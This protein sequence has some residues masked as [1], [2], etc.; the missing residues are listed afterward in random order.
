MSACVQHS[1]QPFL[2]RSVSAEEKLGEF[3]ARWERQ[4]PLLWV[5]VAAA[6]GI[7]IDRWASF[8]LLPWC[9][10]AVFLF[11]LT[12]VL[13]V[14]RRLCISAV[15]LL[16]GVG[17]VSGIWHHDR[18]NIYPV[19]EVSRLAGNEPSPLVVRVMVLDAPRIRPA[20]EEGPLLTVPRGETTR[21]R[22]RALA[23]REGTEWRRVSG[24]LALIVEG[25]VEQLKAWRGDQLEV[26]ALLA[27]VR[28]PL[29]PGEPNFASMYR[30]RRRRAVLLC[31]HV[32]CIRR[33]HSGRWWSF[34]RQL[35]RLRHE[36]EGVLERYVGPRRGPLAAALLLGARHRL[37]PET[38]NTFFLSGSLHFLA[39]SG[40]HVGIL[41]TAF[42]LLLRLQWLPR[43]HVLWAAGIVVVNYALLTGARP[44]V[45]RA[46]ILIVLYCAARGTGRFS[47]AW[48]SL[49]AAGLVTLALC[50]AGLFD[51]GTQLSFLAVASLICLWPIFAPRAA[52]D[53]LRQLIIRS[54]PP[55][56]RLV[57]GGLM[58]AGR[59]LLV[60]AVVWS[61]SVPLVAY[62]FHLIAPVGL[63]LTVLL[64]LPLAAALFAA[65]LTVLTAPLPWLPL[66]F[67]SCCDVC[68]A[69]IEWLTGWAAGCGWGHAW[70]SGPPWWWCVV[71]YGGLFSWRFTPL[72]QLNKRWWIAIC[73][74][75]FMVWIACGS[76]ATRMRRS[77]TEQP[78]R[79]SF[80]AVGHG[81]AVLVELP[82]G[83]TLLYDAGRMGS[84][85]SAVLPVSSVLWA[86]RIHHID[87]LVLSHADADHYNAV[88][89]LLDR[90]SVGIVYV[91][92]VMFD[93][94][95]PGL[96]VLQAA[97]EDARVGWAELEENMMLDTGTGVE[98]RVA[99]PPPRG[100]GGRTAGGGD[101][102]NSVVLE[103]SF[104][105]HRTLLTGDLEGRGLDEL[106]A[107]LPARTDVLLAPH[108]G[109]PRSRPAE[110]VKWAKPTFVVI[111]AGAGFR[112]ER[113]EPV[114]G[115]NGARV[116]WT[117]RDGMVEMVSDGRRLQVSAW[118]A[119]KK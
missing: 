14:S 60:S 53:P 46:V 70:V 16:S 32:E 20:A 95:D 68:L 52:G 94:Q 100:C 109:S 10:L 116:F 41:A 45:V 115:G 27:R 3:R 38:V 96:E 83:K 58:R 57:R 111:S 75:W 44:P 5:L 104:G 85:R 6:T 99:H 80:I 89:E 35:G 64:W 19:D 73:C 31:D 11:V 21:Y 79:V 24:R 23:V 106:L 63:G 102:A 77:V 107:E 113:A 26:A 88:P 110:M 56:M 91:S 7:C 69:V 17:A 84:P 92:P 28:L 8:P 62:R 1:G 50:P 74:G 82:D 118:R 36:A 30:G 117:H 37:P 108:H 43:Y 112:M 54:R 13:L 42:W 66:L 12:A 87:A 55:W 98:L 72:A 25:N 47:Q 40:L 86:R 51:T 105:R 97:L 93:G 61:I 29:N 49:A 76:P 9:L 15:V 18:W 101:N 71:F 103:L 65:L 81:N 2:G 34:L 67:G 22:V 48:N 4:R 90:F 114:Y 59:L 33:V 78:L 119:R 39:I